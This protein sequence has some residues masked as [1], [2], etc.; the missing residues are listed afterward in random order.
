MFCYHYI[1]GVLMR[2]SAGVAVEYPLFEFD[3]L[4][5]PI[6]GQELSGDVEVFIN[7]PIGRCGQKRLFHKN[8]E[9]VKSPWPGKALII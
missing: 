5:I 1:H 4:P 2:N 3:N 6:V 7:S 9:R 8:V